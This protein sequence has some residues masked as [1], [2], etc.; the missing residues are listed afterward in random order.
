MHRRAR[1][2][3]GRPRFL[4][5]TDQS[6]CWVHSRLTRLR[7]GGDALR[8]EL[9]GD[10]PVA[11]LGV[12]V[13][14]VE[15]GVDQVRV[16]PVA[17]A[18]RVGAATGRRPAWRSR[19]P[20]RSPRRGSRRRP[21]QGPAGTSFWERVPGEVR[22]RPA[23]DLV[24]LL[25]LLGALAQLAVLRLQITAAARRPVGGRCRSPSSRSA[26]CNQRFRQDSEI[27]KLFATCAIDWSP[28]RATAITSRAEL[29]RERLGHDADP[30]SE[31]ARPHR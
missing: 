30:S 25:E 26:I 21:G 6:R 24:L 19:A 3:G 27:P 4:A 28:W 14:D 31:D 9:V 7:A 23:Q 8:G 10:E 12:V 29:L 22:R 1:A 13:V 18:D 15:R 5:W 2:C 20:G 11:E 17:L 16:V